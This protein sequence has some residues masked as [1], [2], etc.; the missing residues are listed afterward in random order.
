M[1]K[2]RETYL[3]LMIMFSFCLV[4]I[5]MK[6]EAGIGL[7]PVL[8]EK[9]DGGSHSFFQKQKETGA[10]IQDL[11][12]LTEGLKTENILLQE[13]TYYAREQ[14]TDLKSEQEVREYAEQLKKKF[15]E[16]QWTE[17]N[18][19][20]SWELTAVSPT[21]NHHTEMLQIMATHTKQPLTAYTVYRVSGKQW[22]EA[23]EAFFKSPEFENRHSDIFREKPTVFACV[24]G[25]YSDTIDR[26]L[27][28]TAKKLLSGFK[29]TE[30][31]ALKEETFMSV[32]AASPLFFDSIDTKNEN[33][34][35]QIGLRSE[36]LGGKTTVVVGTPIITIEY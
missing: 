36:G 33:M 4:V 35:L 16:W 13:W 23:S 11:A 8:A 14:V 24:K 2:N 9:T 12:K 34:N 31:E 18:T 25:L 20:E 26:A 17:K 1:K 28:E 29:A 32:S 27:P 5:G 22:N 19:A 10:P 30:I 21:S 15:P 7:K 3:Y 6:T